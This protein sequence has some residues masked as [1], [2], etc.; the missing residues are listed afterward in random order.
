MITTV[1]KCMGSFSSV[2]EGVDHLLFDG[3]IPAFRNFF[4][5]YKYTLEDQSKLM[6]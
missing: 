3:V 2:P 6:V 1:L 5:E 4:E